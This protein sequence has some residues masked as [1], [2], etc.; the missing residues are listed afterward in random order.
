MQSFEFQ[1]DL[2]KHCVDIIQIRI[3]F[4][5]KKMCSY[6]WDR[7][8]ENS[9]AVILILMK[10]RIADSFPAVQLT[11]MVWGGFCNVGMT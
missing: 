7:I 3:Y 11:T 4:E 9:A 5:K 1:S 10:F 6:N 8:W 2:E